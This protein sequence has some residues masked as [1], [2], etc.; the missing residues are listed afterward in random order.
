[1][2]TMP[3]QMLAG[4][5]NMRLPSQKQ[6]LSVDGSSASF[7]HCAGPDLPHLRLPDP[8]AQKPAPPP[9][10]YVS[11]L[12][13]IRRLIVTGYDTP[14]VPYGS[15]RD[16]W[17]ARILPLYEVERRNFMFAAQSTN[18]LAVKQ[19]YDL[20]PNN[21]VLYLSPPKDASEE[22]TQMAETGWCKCLAMEDWVLGYLRMSDPQ[23]AE[24]QD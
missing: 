24:A 19:A 18:W 11:L 6:P 21:P 9:P 13:Y 20:G 10:V 23:A 5:I 7:S 17:Q 2:H 16:D 15:F 8:V 4:L 12:P 14:G 3:V 1:M 22:V